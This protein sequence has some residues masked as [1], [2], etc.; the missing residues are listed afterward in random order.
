MYKHEYWAIS[1][2]MGAHY[3]FPLPI[4]LTMYCH[5]CYLNSQNSFTHVIKLLAIIIHSVSI[6]AEIF[7]GFLLYHKMSSTSWNKIHIQALRYSNILL[8]HCTVL[9]WI[10]SMHLQL[11]VHTYINPANINWLLKML[12]S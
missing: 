12:T 5:D 3:T 7:M 1:S 10:Q 8:M 9:Y 6:Y 11:Y 2:L 4:W